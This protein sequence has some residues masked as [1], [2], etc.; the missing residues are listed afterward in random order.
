M[1]ALRRWWLQHRLQ[2]LLIAVLLGGAWAFRQ[3]QGAAY[4]ELYGWLAQPFTANPTRPERVAFA[5]VQ[6]LHIRLAE[7][8]AQNKKLQSL[9]RYVSSQPKPG[10]IA[11]IIGRSADH[12][13]QQVILGRGTQ[14]GM[15]VGD[16]VA[17]PGG[18]IGRV[19]Q[20]TPNTSRVLLVSDATSRIGVVISRTRF[21]GVIRGQ[22]NNQALLEFFN[23][24]PDV[25]P[26]DMVST[27]TF[28][29]LFPAGLPVGRVVSINLN[30]NPAPEAVVELTAPLNFLETAVVYP[31]QPLLDGRSDEQNP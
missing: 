19:T 24:D 22:G 15:N 25:R 12:W 9:L 14:H 16:V 20:V 8:E 28:S 17:G 30:K 27:S 3:T 11:P 13:W 2:V 4:A 21:L 10:I 1:F 5:E 6:E 31:H 18:I 23:K 7:S 26:G 29:Q